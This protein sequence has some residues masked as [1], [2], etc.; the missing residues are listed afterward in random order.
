MT[1]RPLLTLAAVTSVLLAACAQTPNATLAQFDPAANPT[2]AVPTQLTGSRISRNVVPDDRHPQTSSNLK[3][4]T[5]EDIL[6]AGYTDLNS[7]LNKQTIGRR[8]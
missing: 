5:R 7:F 4:I 3:V 2:G 1:R 6:K 8:P